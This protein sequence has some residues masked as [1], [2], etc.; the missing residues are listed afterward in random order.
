MKIYVSQLNPKIGDLKNNTK[1]I[2]NEIEKAKKQK[3]DIVLF[4]ECIICGYPPED[5]LLFDKFLDELDSSLEDI[6]QASNN[7]F[8]VIGTVRKNPEK[9]EKP[10]CNSAVV[11]H[12][13]KILGYKDKTLLPT[14]DVFDE[15]RYFEPG[16]KQKVF[17]YKNKKI[18]ILICEDAW[19][20][21]N[22]IIYTKY[23]QDPVEDIKKLSPDL[24][25]NLSAS[26]YHYKK[27][28]LRIDIN[29][30]TAITLNCPVI[31]ANQVGGNDQLVFD[32][33]SMYLNEK[34]EILHLAK[35]FQEDSFLVDLD[36]R[37]IP[38]IY[39][40]D[41]VKDLY[42][43]LVLGIKDY[44]SKLNLKKACIG[45]S[46]GI[47]SALSLCIARDA[48]GKENVFPINMP[49]RFSSVESME[50]SH[51]LCNNLHI[52]LKDVPI[53]HLFQEYL[54]LL[55]P[56]FLDKKFDTTEENIQARIRGMILMAISNKLN[57]VVL[58]TGNK[59]EMAMGYVTLY[60]DMCGGL[61]VLIDVSKTLVYKLC[62]YVN[63][64]KEIIPASIIKKEPSAELKANQKD[65][66][67]LPKYSIVDK[68]LNGYIEEHLSIDEISQKYLLNKKLVKDL[69][70]RIHAAEYKR[71]QGPPG[72]RVSKKS[73][74]KG[75]FFPIVHGW[76]N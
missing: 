31:M 64:D 70:K 33:H 19:Q 63:K 67:D 26:P 58:S 43:A 8:A 65:T 52:K 18:G 69:V 53:D 36:K 4:S 1:K 42:D 29:K 37:T 23:E 9:K 41:A 28:G 47:D 61:S 20:H 48:L 13:Q 25:L 68:V 72:I 74:T 75:R 34:G 14:Y 60:G 73:F 15:R 76:S 22:K 39:K 45:L 46:G 38:F 62:G 7:I 57:Y 35:G 71:R 56:F 27:Q 51:N 54:N 12:N 6:V 44:F 11:I 30:K 59:S 66:D 2:I 17:E 49:S 50:D 32:G 55:S 21:A 40:E 5:L 3:A 16:E 24:I 10:L